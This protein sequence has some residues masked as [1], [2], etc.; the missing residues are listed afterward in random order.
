MQ[1]LPSHLNMWRAVLQMS[2]PLLGVITGFASLEF[3]EFKEGFLVFAMQVVGVNSNV[4]K[5][6]FLADGT[7]CLF[8]YIFLLDISVACNPALM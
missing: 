5:A 7:L 2:E 3:N 4:K 6:C 8:S 1:C